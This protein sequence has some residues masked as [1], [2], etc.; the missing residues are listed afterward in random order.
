MKSKNNQVPILL[1]LLVV[2]CQSPGPAASMAQEAPY[3]TI[4][5][6]IGTY[7]EESNALKHVKKARLYVKD[8]SYFFNEI[9]DS[10]YVFAYK[11]DD[12]QTTLNRLHE[13]R[14]HPYFR[15][16]WFYRHKSQ[17][18]ANTWKT[19]KQPEK[20]S[21][22]VSQAVKPEKHTA[23]VAQEETGSAVA[24]KKIVPEQPER[25]L[26]TD[27]GVPATAPLKATMTDQNI[28]SQLQTAKSGDIIIFN[29]LLFYRNAA[30]L[31]QSSESELKKLLAVMLDNQQM[32]I[33]I[34]GHTNGDFRGEIVTMGKRSK[35]YFKTSAKNK[36][37]DGDAVALSLERARIIS[38]YLKEK[39][40]L[41]ERIEI[42][43]WGGEKTVYPLNSANASLNSRVE[44]EIL[45]K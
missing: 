41:P 1:F 2:I 26:A 22:E 17:H 6:I 39:G 28:T 25:D 15:D 14:A 34:H 20:P 5:I 23:T 13:L 45:E 32:K 31:Q 10:F 42:K 44:I 3:H 18:T 36:Y 12:K 37:V 16:A 9:K 40:I 29:N 24:V 4:Y 43:G 19:N 30:I 11:S 35:S 27:S 8:A 38:R 7:A 33:R 21:V